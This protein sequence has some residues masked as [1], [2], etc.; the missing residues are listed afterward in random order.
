MSVTLFS[1]YIRGNVTQIGY[2]PRKEN[3]VFDDDGE[4][5]PWLHDPLP[6]KGKGKVGLLSIP[7]SREAKD[8]E[9]PSK[10]RFDEVEK[11][12]RILRKNVDRAVKNGTTRKDFERYRYKCINLKL[13]VRKSELII[14]EKKSSFIKETNEIEKKLQLITISEEQ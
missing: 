7:A 3:R 9:V 2:K 6:S 8:N 12:L 1:G 14:P 4:Y 11:F 10:T 5:Y 13:Y